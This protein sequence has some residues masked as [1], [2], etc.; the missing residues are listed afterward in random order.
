[1]AKTFAFTEL[2]VFNTLSILDPNSEM[3]VYTQ[4]GL[5]VTARKFNSNGNTTAETADTVQG[6]VGYNTTTVPPLSLGAVDID[7][8]AKNGDSSNNSL[9][10]TA[11]ND[12]VYWD[13]ATLYS[14]STLSV[15]IGVA[16]VS[17]YN[18]PSADQ[19]AAIEVFDLDDG[20]DIL[21]LTHS[22]QEF[23]VSGL[24]TP[25]QAYAYAATAY[26]GEGSDII[27][28]GNQ[29]DALFGD[30]GDDRMD[31]GAG[32]DTLFGGLGWTSWKA[33]AGMT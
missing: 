25:P 24:L 30:A 9:R 23:L 15:P 6:V 3:L 11:A 16:V 28:S 31:G 17:R 8:L 7:V 4:L 27:W 21:N 5:N 22:N 12:I 1:M 20:D 32:H 29:N 33:A 26:G 10:A 13:Y 14:L 19:N 18:L 2:T